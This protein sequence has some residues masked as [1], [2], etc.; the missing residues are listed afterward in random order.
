DSLA[1][2]CFAHI[3]V[4][5]RRQE[6]LRYGLGARAAI[7]GLTGLSSSRIS[8]YAHQIEVT[9][10]VLEDPVQR[11]LLADEVGLGKTIEAGIVLRQ[12]LLDNPVEQA[13]LVVPTFLLDQWRFEL[14]TKFT[15]GDLGTKRVTRVSAADLPRMR[16]QERFGLLIVDEAHHAAAG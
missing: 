2:Y 16:L 5:D 13:L 11:Y 9:R 15:L 1:N 6:F 4:H 3:A 10:R 7:L 8:L 14:L 12:F